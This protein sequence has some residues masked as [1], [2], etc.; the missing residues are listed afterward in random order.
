MLLYL[1]LRLRYIVLKKLAVFLYRG[2]RDI[3]KMTIM[4][5]G[6]G[7]IVFDNL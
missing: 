4:E 1:Y 2:T 7:I 5:A 3:D 6:K